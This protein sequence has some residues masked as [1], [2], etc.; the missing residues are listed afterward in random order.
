MAEYINMQQ[1]EY[2]DLQ[3]KLES[4]HDDIISGDEKVRTAIETLVSIDGGFHIADVSTKIDTLLE[5]LNTDV[6]EKL[7]TVFEDSESAIS[8][9]VSTVLLIDVIDS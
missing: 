3:T 8:E 2:D 1:T 4:L 6:M 9:Y 7:K 5:S